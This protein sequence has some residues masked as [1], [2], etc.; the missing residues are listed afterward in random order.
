MGTNGM[1]GPI[2][3]EIGIAGSASCSI[4]GMEPASGIAGA[5]KT[6]PVEI[7]PTPPVGGLSTQR[8][9]GTV[10][11]RQGRRNRLAA[12]KGLTNDAVVCTLC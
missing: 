12:S 8:R 11:R 2:K 9:P 6:T 10:V 3:H 4:W 7:L 5:I 1:E